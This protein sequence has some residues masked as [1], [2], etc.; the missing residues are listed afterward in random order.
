MPEYRRLWQPGGTFFFTVVF[1]GRQ[2]ILDDARAVRL[3]GEAMRQARAD[4]PFVTVGVVLLPDHLHTLWT[5]PADDTAYHIRWGTVKSR[6]TRQWLR[7]R[8]AA[9]RSLT[10]AQRRQGRRGLWQPRYLEHTIRDERDLEDHLNYIHCNPVKHGYVACPRD[11]PHSTFH[12]YVAD[13]W[14]PADWA[15]GS[16]PPPP[17]LDHDYLEGRLE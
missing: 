8:P 3:L 4:H 9:E 12:R 16:R 14:Y 7:I 10:N 15:C 13:G 1:A 11:W 6:F 17:D 5:L 2:P